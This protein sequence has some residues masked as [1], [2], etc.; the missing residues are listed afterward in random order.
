MGR[1]D[2]I[3]YRTEAERA[4]WGM[5]VHGPLIRGHVMG[6]LRVCAYLFE[7]G[8]LFGKISTS[9]PFAVARSPLPSSP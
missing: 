5:V 3:Q 6:V 4:R 2:P 9:K 1:P 7:H 8:F